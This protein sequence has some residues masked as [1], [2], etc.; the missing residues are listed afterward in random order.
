MRLLRILL[1]MLLPS[2]LMVLA[3]PAPPAAACSC[4]GGDA[5]DFAEWADTVFV[6]T[7]VEV[8]MP[9]MAPVIGSTDTVMYEFQVSTAYEGDAR[10]RT[11]VRSVRFGASCGLEGLVP[12][13]S[14]VVF[15]GHRTIDG[16]P[17]DALWANLCGGTAP[18]R[19]QRVADVE[20][21]LGSGAAPQAGVSG[22]PGHPL[23]P[24]LRSLTAWASRVIVVLEH[25][26]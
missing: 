18:A 20:A 1:V 11:Y 14:Y 5:V 22:A 19:S 15:A 23:A 24:A 12:Q 17:S 10:E 21:V 6:G 8:T 9:P 26:G 3:A 13:Q 2:C 7:L 4:V 25:L 16:E